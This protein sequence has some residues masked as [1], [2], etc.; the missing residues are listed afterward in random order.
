[1]ATKTEGKRALADLG[2]GKFS[3][4]MVDAIKDHVGAIEAELQRVGAL[5]DG[6][7]NELRQQEYK[8]LRLEADLR[9][10]NARAY[11]LLKA[12]ALTE[13]ALRETKR[14]AASVVEFLPVARD[15]AEAG[16]KK[17]LA[18]LST[19]D[20]KGKFEELKAHPLTEKALREIER[21]AVQVGEYLPVAR[22]RAAEGSKQAL[23]YLSTVDL[24]AGF[25]NL[26]AHPMTEKAACEIERQ[27]RSARDHLPAARKQVA[28]AVEKASAYIADLHKKAA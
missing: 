10:A 13:I 14:G 16:S 19:V 22:K 17:T 24:K 21:L 1:M 7:A 2:A 27:L 6:A 26:K 11:A 20:F 4:E 8:I 25:E 28:V 15:Y 5:H 12:N 18:Y 9:A 23:A 3:F